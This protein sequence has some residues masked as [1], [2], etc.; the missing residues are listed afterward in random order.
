MRKKIFILLSFGLFLLFSNLYSQD[1]RWLYLKS[2]DDIFVY[3]DTETV[4][5]GDNSTIV[6][7]KFIN[8]DDNVNQ[9]VIYK[10]EFYPCKDYYKL[11]TVTIYPKEGFPFTYTY[12]EIK[13][14]ISDS[15][16]ESAY[17]LFY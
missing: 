16:E 2:I 9:Y 11:I 5:Q 3:Y 12:N 14:I 1:D 7:L 6:L 8:V 4:K 15:F 13:E 17:R 10:M